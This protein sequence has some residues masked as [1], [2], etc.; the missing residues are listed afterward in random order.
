MKEFFGGC[1]TFKGIAGLS[2]RGDSVSVVA[3]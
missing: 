2:V 1:D 3:G